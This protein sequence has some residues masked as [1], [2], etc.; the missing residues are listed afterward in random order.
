MAI[1]KNVLG[2]DLGTHTLKAAE[3]AQGLRSL[4]VVRMHAE[5]RS[6]GLP[7]SEQIDRLLLTHS[8]SREHVVTA[9]RGDRVSVRMLDFPFSE[10]RRLAQAVPFEIEDRVPFDVDRMQVDWDVASSERNRASV[11]SALAPRE[12]VS[13]LV[14]TLH[15]ARC[16]A[17]VV[18]A[19][20]LV[21]ANLG[22]LF[23]LPEPCLLMD[24]GHAKTTFC[25]LDGGRAL[26]ARS[27]GLAGLAF[28][29]SIA[30]ERGLSLPDAERFKHE[31]G[32]AGV[33]RAEELL[34]RLA[35]EVLRFATAA[36]PRLR[37]PVSQIVL[38]GGG[39]LLEGLARALTEYS[40]IPAE[41]LALPEDDAGLGLAAV[42]APGVLAPSLALALRGSARAR[43]G[44]NLRQDEFA[45]RT[46]F[47]WLR[48]EFGTTGRL[49]A[50]V[51][52][53]ALL[54]F[55][56]GAVLEG[57]EAH[58]VE[59]R[60]AALYAEAFPGRPIPD[61][62]MT[63]MREAVRE[64][65]ERAEFLGV[66]RGNLSALDVLSEISRRIPQDLD[67]GFEELS[68]DKQ[69]VRVRVYSK[70]FEAADRLGAE[71]SKFGPFEQAR[72][73]AIETDKRT[74]IKKFNVTI[75]LAARSE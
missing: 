61:S 36:E 29:E 1:L 43:S 11:I 39:S 12:E 41:P 63:A 37:G 71:L 66:Y 8:F 24:V 6:P 3:L 42:G 15:A 35:N 67:V 40:G 27:I 68:I 75:S 44:I 52:V 34:R 70:S 14:E 64:A 38:L 45:R 10:K 31:S 48:R 49:A 4:E 32:V 22:A 57:R 28:T 7:L 69:T 56:V 60:A 19:E 30:Q 23:P 53:L 73:G 62:P 47:S 59:S 74:G 21:L 9:V 17:R 33:A 54:S 5:P 2:L 20:G 65:N 26:A 58:T 13:Q 72:I 50:G 51:A 46:D 25:A 18:E 16:D 55:A